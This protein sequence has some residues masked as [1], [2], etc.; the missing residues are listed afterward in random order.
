MKRKKNLKI[1]ALAII[2]YIPLSLSA[3]YRLYNY[4]ALPPEAYTNDSLVHF[5]A[6]ASFPYH[7]P[8][9]KLLKGLVERY[10]YDLPFS[11]PASN[12]IPYR[13]EIFRENRHY[14]INSLQ[15]P[16]YHI[17]RDT[18]LYFNQN[19]AVYQFRKKRWYIPLQNHD[20][21]GRNGKWL[22]FQDGEWTSVLFNNKSKKIKK[23]KKRIIS[24]KLDAILVERDSLFLE[25]KKKK[26]YL[27]LAAAKVNT[28]TGYARGYF[29]N[30]KITYDRGA[31]F[32]CFT[33]NNN[34]LYA[35]LSTG[36][37]LIYTSS[38]PM[39]V[40][41]FPLRLYPTDGCGAPS[42]DPDYAPSLLSEGCFILKEKGKLGLIDT[43]GVLRI[44]FMLDSI[45]GDFQRGLLAVRILNKWGYVDLKG[46][47][48]IPPQYDEARP[49]YDRLTA[50]K[51]DGKWG[52]I[53]QKG[54]L[55]IPYQYIRANPFMFGQATVRAENK[56]SSHRIDTS[57]KVIEEEVVKY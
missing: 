9:G 54:D 51:L 32:A 13:F 21:I 7:D 26:T 23:I 8:K 28:H 17:R 39:S 25:E 41:R 46:Q 40:E 48:V 34:K 20:F 16:F 19:G 2:I 12:G 35:R 42:I 18:L 44:P 52:Y 14:Q 15:M 50:V 45:E 33:L 47:E 57:N 49:F 22:I 4:V 5:N 11:E 6:G 1:V 38:E 30:N 31:S 3:Q 53:N 55:V 27:G 29:Q 24:D 43:N 56:D 10:A 36:Y 37:K